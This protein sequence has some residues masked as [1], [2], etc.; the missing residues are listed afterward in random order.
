[1]NIGFLLRAV[2]LACFILACAGG[3]FFGVPPVP[4]GLALW[5]GS[6]FA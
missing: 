4:V 5:V 2:A 6:T 1:M 3:S